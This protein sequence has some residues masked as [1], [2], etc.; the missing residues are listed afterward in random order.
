[1]SAKRLKII[2]VEFENL[3]HFD[4]G[5]FKVDL[6]ATD[7]VFN[8]SELYKISGSAYTQN[9]IGFIGLNA[10]GKTT[11]LRLLK[12][13]LNIIIHNAPLNALNINDM[14]KDG[15]IIRTVFFY[16]DAYYQLESTIGID[17]DNKV[18]PF[19]YRAETLKSKKFDTVKSRNDLLDFESTRNVDVQERSELDSEIKN[20]LDDDKSFINP[21]IKSNGIYLFDN[22]WLNYVN[23]ANT[24]GETPSDILEIFD[25]SIES[26]S[27]KNM[28]DK[29]AEWKLKFKGDD[30]F[31]KASEP[32]AL[33]LLLSTGT[34]RGQG[35]IQN[36]IEALKKGGYLIID[37]LEMH[38]NKELVKVI[39]GLF[40]S[41][42]TNP[43]G[44]CLIFST[45]Y[46]EILDTIDRKDNIYITR[47]KNQLLSVSKFADEFKRNDF[48]K[49]EIILSNTLSG[50]APKYESIQKL[51]DYIC[52][53]L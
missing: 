14:I 1:M 30:V 51:R 20:Y 33:N 49:S 6:F 36:A 34:I 19:Y 26:L 12:I 22:L 9:V 29:S 50:T 24:S 37:E 10:T 8:K 44:A 15:T 39:L 13:A 45:H 7:R 23:I 18:K 42:Q 5:K 32:I 2:C 40:K 25:D 38:L 35:L 16:G 48:K 11:A 47:K 3:N 52:R 53:L 43:Y 17:A 4:K 46:P 27:I 31:Y 21:I 41:K 28:P